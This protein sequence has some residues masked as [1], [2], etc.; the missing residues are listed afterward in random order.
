MSIKAGSILNP[1]RL[2]SFF[3][4]K[5]IYLLIVRRPKAVYYPVTPTQLGWLGRDFPCL[6]ICRI[7]RVKTVIHL[8]GGGLKLN[9][10]TFHPGIKWMTK[11]ACMTVSKALVQA[12]VLRDQF[13]DLAR[14]GRISVLY[15]AIDT[16]RYDNPDLANHASGELLF[17]GH[18][19][20][21]K[22]Y[23]D[24]VRAIPLVAERFPQVKF[25]FAGNIRKGERCVYFNQTN[26]KAI[27]YED[28]FDLH[29]YIQRSD[30]NYN[31]KYLGVVTGEDK[32]KLLRNCT[33]LI[34]PSYSEGFS[35]SLLEGLS[36]GK[37]VI[38]TPVGAHKEVIRDGE[39][40][41]VVEPG[42][43]T[44]LA[45]TII[46]LLENKP[47]RDKMAK[48]NYEYARSHFDIDIIAGRLRDYINEVVQEDR[49]IVL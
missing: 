4:L 5:L 30:Y 47:L 19:T 31:Y 3:F 7:L 35:R 49:G 10:Q 43:I 34:L 39:H 46:R 40:G 12:E 38:C 17:L 26:G 21:A 20:K 18:L 48:A 14:K 36:M 37:P 8:R 2:Y 9:L 45:E 15:N 27:E 29:Q 32:L 13:G 16:K 22:G 42:N 11:T 24:L 25:L 33:A 6:M 41:F 23:C 28:P 1:F 44:Q